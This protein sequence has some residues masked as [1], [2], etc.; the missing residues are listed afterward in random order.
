[1]ATL[2]KINSNFS[3]GELDPRLHARVDFEGYYRGAKKLRNVL[4]IPTGGVRRRFGTRFLAKITVVTTA[5]ELKLVKLDISGNTYCIIFKPLILNIY[6]EGVLVATLPT[7]YTA[8]DI[9]NINIT[10]RVNDLIIVD[11]VHDPRVLELVAHPSSWIIGTAVFRFFPTFDFQDI[12]YDSATFLP[13]GVS[14]DITLTSSIPVFDTE[15][16]GGTYDSSLGGSMRITGFTSSIEIT[17]F[18]VQDFPNTNSILGTLSVLSKPAF[19]TLRGFPKTATFFQNRLWFGGTSSILNGVWGSVINDFFN[20]NVNRG[21]DTDAIVEAVTGLGN[22]EIIHIF[23]TRSLV[24]FT[25]DGEFSTSVIQED[26]VTPDTI[27]FT[28][29]TKNGISFPEVKEIDNRIIYVDTG[30]KIIRRLAYDS[31]RG[32]YQDDNISLLSSQLIDN[33][34]DTTTFENPDVDDGVYY[35]AVNQDGTLAIFQSL[36]SQRVSSW[37]LQTTDGFFRKVDSIEDEMSFIVERQIDGNTEFYLEELDFGVFTDSATVQ[38]FGSPTTVINTGL[39]HL[40]GK[41]VRVIGDGLV[42]KKQTV[43]GGSITLERAVSNVEIGLNYDPLII[44]MPL[45][46]AFETGN[47]LYLPKRIK[48]VFI[49]FFES[50]GIFVNDRLVSSLEFSP[51]DPEYPT[52]PKTNFEEITLLIGWDPRVE[53]QI[54]QKDP[55]PMTII[56]IGFAVD[57]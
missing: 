41:E 16:V 18:T 14:G 1:M 27:S 29:Q 34:Q 46:I 33:P 10:R 57:A 17:G 32:S 38:T 20:F 21:L 12:N 45:N 54:T 7:P 26:A 19:S 3:L 31:G 35:T 50:L 49:D 53:I 55:L 13:G 22:T 6:F 8:S 44:P 47:D 30:G 15:H 4:S 52:T 51:G 36:E 23:P 2:F 24:V 28:E 40:E 9:P 37:T 11:G 56:G 5:A 25:K 39:S 43:V 42:L 48:T